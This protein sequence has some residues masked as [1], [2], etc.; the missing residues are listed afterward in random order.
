LATHGA[1]GIRRIACSSRASILA[2]NDARGN[3]G[4]GHLMVYDLASGKLLSELRQDSQSGVEF[5][6]MS[7]TPNGSQIAVLLENP[8]W[9]QIRGPDLEIRNARDLKQ[10]IYIST[11]DMP[12]DVAFVGDSEIVTAHGDR[13]GDP[14]P[15][16]NFLRLWDTRTGKELRRLSDPQLIA[17]GPINASSNGQ[18]LIAE[19]VKYHICHL[20][21]GLEGRVDVKEQRF[22]VWS[23][24]TGRQLFR[25]NP[26]GP[27]IEPLG[28]L[29]ILSDDGSAALIY[30]PHSEVTPKVVPILQH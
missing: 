30:W 28:A 24:S 15:S 10:A 27:I 14:R 12:S 4:W 19:I 26:F 17:E 23:T 13:A 6:A 8:R 5:G 18:K 11:D 25:S 1:L 2:V 22:A 16:K 7:M 9:K 29:C 20:C 21:D 3:Y